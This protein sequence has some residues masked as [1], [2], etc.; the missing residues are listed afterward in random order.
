MNMKKKVMRLKKSLYGLK[1]SEANRSKKIS[2]CLSSYYRLKE[3]S[4]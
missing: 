1:Q 3:I 4:N 2:N